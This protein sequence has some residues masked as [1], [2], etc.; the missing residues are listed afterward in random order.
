MVAAVVGVL[1]TLSAPLVSERIRRQDADATRMR[2]AFEQRRAAYVTINQSVREFHDRLKYAVHRLLE[3]NYTDQAR[4]DLEDSRLAYR[5]R[6]AEAQM[7]A[8]TSILDLCRDLNTTLTNADAAV[9][10]IVA[11][12]PRQGESAEDLRQD[13][14]KLAEGKISHLTSVMRADLGVAGAD[15]ANVTVLGHSL[16]AT[17]RLATP[18]NR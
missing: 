16:T 12:E 13:L 9:K 6:Y 17:A 5:S 18:R 2:L 15:L 3:G 8:P 1:G 14:L 11:G 7:V 10:R 4:A